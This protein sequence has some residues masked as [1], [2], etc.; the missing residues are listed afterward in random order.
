MDTD[1]RAAGSSKVDRSTISDARRG[2]GRMRRWWCLRLPL[3]GGVFV[4]RL[5]SPGELP[6]L[7]DPFDLA[8]ARQP[9]VIPDRD[10]AYA[11]YA[12][13]ENQARGHARGDRERGV[14]CQ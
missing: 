14:G 1:T 7:G 9:I 12:R 3:V 13:G 6:D 10:N 4:W 11:A 5:R 8:R 2:F